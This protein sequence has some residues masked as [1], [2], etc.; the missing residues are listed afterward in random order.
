MVQI[1][2]RFKNK[3]LSTSKITNKKKCRCCGIL[4]QSI[5]IE[6]RILPTS[7]LKAL[8]AYTIKFRYSELELTRDINLEYR[9][10]P[11][12]NPW[13][14]QTKITVYWKCVIVVFNCIRTG[15]FKRI[16]LKVNISHHRCVISRSI[17]RFLSIFVLFEFV[18]HLMRSFI[19]LLCSKLGLFDILL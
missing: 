14:G 3:I 6:L 5:S 11:S 16:D 18:I 2:F 4:L 9:Y 12:S 1:G 19:I 13:I 17:K 7:L 15:L 8:T 10:N